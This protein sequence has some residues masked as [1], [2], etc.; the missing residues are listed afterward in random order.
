MATRHV[1]ITVPLWMVSWPG[2][3]TAVPAPSATVAKLIGVGYLAETNPATFTAAT[4]DHV[5][6]REFTD[7]DLERLRSYA[8][9]GEPDAV[10]LL[11][12]YDAAEPAA[13]P[14]PTAEPATQPS[15]F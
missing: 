6:V 12:M 10:A 15:M 7:K 9:V 2:G 8:A 14:S 13:R 11:N 1:E 5:A 4:K 3:Y